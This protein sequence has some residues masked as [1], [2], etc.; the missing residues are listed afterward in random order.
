MKNTAAMQHLSVT[1]TPLG[2]DCG[3]GAVETEGH[4]DV[5]LPGFAASAGRGGSCISSGFYLSTSRAPGAMPIFKRTTAVRCVVGDD[6]NPSSS[7]KQERCKGGV[8][9]RTKQ[10]QR[11]QAGMLKSPPLA[12]SGNGGRLTLITTKSTHSD[13]RPSRNRA[14]DGR[15]ETGNEPS[16]SPLRRTAHH[17]SKETARAIIGAG[18]HAMLRGWN[19]FEEDLKQD[20]ARQGVRNTVHP[21]YALSSVREDNGTGLEEGGKSVPGCQTGAPAATLGSRGGCTG[22]SLQVVGDI[23]SDDASTAQEG[24]VTS[25][26]KIHDADNNQL[27][28]YRDNQAGNKH[29][30]GDSPVFLTAGEHAASLDRLV[31]PLPKPTVLSF[32][33]DDSDDGGNDGDDDRV[34]D[35]GTKI[36]N[37]SFDHD[38][39]PDGL[40]KRR[41]GGGG[42]EGRGD[43]KHSPVARRKRAKTAA[44]RRLQGIIAAYTEPSWAGA[45]NGAVKS[46]AAVA[47]T[48]ASRTTTILPSSSV[49]TDVAAATKLPACEAN[50]R[51]GKKRGRS[52]AN[53]SADEGGCGPGEY[54]GGGSGGMAWRY[55]ARV[56]LSGARLKKLET[57]MEAAM[58][59]LPVTY[60]EYVRQERLA[61][62]RMMYMVRTLGTVHLDF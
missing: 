12:Y 2:A 50:K 37:N 28:H 25:S 23:T 39:E 6:P 45:P 24:R 15:P 41:G 47:A 10:Q 21:V 44:S 18:G 55:G 48:T 13:T 40:T 5:S 9:V 54:E 59:R 38:P 33:L 42:G 31:I 51:L 29:G 11:Q 3:D 8:T 20:Y 27:W 43:A 17:I 34:D 14:E 53:T 56:G 61:H 32:S 36:Y 49:T 46:A 4:H 1:P 26:T 58:E 19:G 52:G 35:G 57:A 62:L 22:D 30:I 60:E 16:K 7:R